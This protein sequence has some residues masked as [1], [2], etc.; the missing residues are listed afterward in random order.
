MLDEAVAGGQRSADRGDR[1]RRA[2]R[3]G[4]AGH[5]AG[6]RS[7]L[8]ADALVLAIGNQEPEP[9]RAFAGAGDRASSAI[10]GAPRR[11]RRSRELAAERRR[12][13][14]DR[15]WLDDGRPGTVA[16]RGGAQGQIL[17]LSRRGLMPRAHA[18][19]DPSPVELDE[20]PQRQPARDCG[21]GCGAQRPRSAGARLSIA[22]DRTATRCG[23][24]S[25]REQQRR[26]LR[27]ARP[28]WDVHRHRI[29][30][31]VARASLG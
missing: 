5:S 18:D 27:H 21:A 30:P 19:F 20:V 7:T 2:A 3:D 4:E 15:H 11:R 14:A 13:A 6:R 1:D 28:W 23:K 12:R 22:C 24:A 9:L 29:A 17:A 10:R 31:Q 25:T 16:R 26:F 8:E